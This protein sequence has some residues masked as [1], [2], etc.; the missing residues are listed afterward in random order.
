MAEDNQP[1]ENNDESEEDLRD[2][3][4]LSIEEIYK[5]KEGRLGLYDLGSYRG[6][7]LLA[8]QMAELA[9]AYKEQTEV[10]QELL[11]E[12]SA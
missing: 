6:S 1:E 7:Q 9:E 10:M 8:N 5:T 11:E 3:E 4:Q 2:E 12:I